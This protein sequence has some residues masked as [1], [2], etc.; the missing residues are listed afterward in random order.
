[1][2]QAPAPLRQQPIWDGVTRLWHWA[3]AFSVTAG[4]LLGRFRDFDTVQ[5]HFYAGYLTGVLLV[6]RLLWGF[7][8]PQPIRFSSLL[9]SLKGLPAYLRGFFSRQPSGSAGHNPLG[10]L[11]VFAMLGLL[12]LQ[13]GSGL[14]VEDDTLFAAGPL[15][16]DIDTDLGKSLASLH[17]INAKF[18]LLVLG[19]HLAAIVF[20]RVW[21][22][23]DLV[24]PMIN[25]KKW[26]KRGY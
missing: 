5:W 14:F 15:A 9:R 7:V 12:A 17:R 22:K 3:F 4:W 6:W 1:M 8:G 25:G 11:S 10:V 13:V 20:Y 26:V 24:T 18:I 16:Y 19:L 23:E 21:K 2:S